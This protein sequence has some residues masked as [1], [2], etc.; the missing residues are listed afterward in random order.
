MTKTFLFFILSFLYG[1]SFGQDLPLKTIAK[2]LKGKN[3][4]LLDEGDYIFKIQHK[5]TKKWGV[6]QWDDYDQSA[7]EIL[8]FAYDSVGWFID[9]Q[10]YMVVKNEDK[11]G[12]FLNPYEITDAAERV[13]CQY[14]QIK[15]IE[16]EGEYFTL[17]AKDGQWG[18]ID[19][20]DD[21]VIVPCL[22]RSATEVPLVYMESWQLPTMKAAQEK[23]NA[24]LV[25][26]DANNGDGAF[27]ARNKTTLKWGMFQDL[28][29]NIDE[30]IPMHYDSLNTFP[31]NGSFTAVYNQGKVGFY[32]CS[33][34]YDEEAKESVPC[35]YEDY[36]RFNNEGTIYLAV[37]KNNKWGWVDWLT[38]EEKSEFKSDSKDDLPYPNYKQ[39][40][41]FDE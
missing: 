23:L 35:M 34:S 9:Y 18:L 29:D 11:Y 14:E 26:F 25:F 1:L 24:D 40:R 28:G 4:E 17:I 41:W 13:D 16:K 3:I 10:P 7:E 5:K 36:Q 37:Q 38:G 31:Y 32:L 6:Y 15:T 30:M 20:F 19:W 12:L 2:Q 8:P 22:Y 33:W 21:F 27:R 39:K